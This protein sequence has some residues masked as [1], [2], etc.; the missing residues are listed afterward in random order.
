[1]CQ[2]N[3]GTCSACGYSL[4]QEHLHDPSNHLLE[5]QILSKLPEALR[6]DKKNQHLILGT[7]RCLLSLEILEKDLKLNKRS[8]EWRN[9]DW[10]TQP[11]LELAMWSEKEIVTA[12]DCAS[13]NCLYTPQR[14]RNVLTKAFYSISSKI[15]HSCI[16]KSR[17]IFTDNDRLECRATVPIKEG[18]SITVSLVDPLLDTYSR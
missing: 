7:I 15:K 17:F 11:L 9:L 2:N 10:L 6:I 5:C 18:E 8:T 14:E 16:S 4:C 13:Y 1:M 12:I 3:T